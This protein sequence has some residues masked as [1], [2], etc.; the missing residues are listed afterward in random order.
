MR[1]LTDAVTREAKRKTSEP[2]A[3]C[4]RFKVSINNEADLH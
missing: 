4:D 1:S 3:K 2:I